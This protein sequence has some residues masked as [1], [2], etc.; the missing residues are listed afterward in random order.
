MRRKIVF[1][2][3]LY[4]KEIVENIN[5]YFFDKGYEIEDVLDAEGGYYI[6]FILKDDDNYQYMKKYTLSDF[7]QNLIEEKQK[8]VKTSTGDIVPNTSTGDKLLN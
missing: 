2:P 4:S 7:K 8:W 5:T 3:K 6:I 1:L